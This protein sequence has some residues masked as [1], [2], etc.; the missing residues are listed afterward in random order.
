V[1]GKSALIAAL[2]VGAV[3]QEIPTVVVIKLDLLCEEV[4]SWL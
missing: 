1:W 3:P 2:S 4:R